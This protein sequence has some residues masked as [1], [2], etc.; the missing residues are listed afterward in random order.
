[1]FLSKRCENSPIAKCENIERNQP[2]YDDQETNVETVTQVGGK[3]VEGAA[4]EKRLERGIR[5]T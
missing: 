5:F 2:G 4:N 3:S 1:M